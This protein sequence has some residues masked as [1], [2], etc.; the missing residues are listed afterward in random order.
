M[1]RN[2]FKLH[3]IGRFAKKRIMKSCSIALV[4]L[5]A[6]FVI[7]FL[8][9][10]KS[11]S[12]KDHDTSN[13]N[14]TIEV[15]LEYRESN[16]NAWTRRYSDDDLEIT[17]IDDENSDPSI[18]SSDQPI[19]EIIDSAV[20]SVINHGKSSSNENDTD[21]VFY[22]EGLTVSFINV[23]QGDS[24]LIQYTDAEEKAS[25][26]IDAGDNSCGTLVRN[27]LSKSGVESIDYVVCTHPDEDHIGGMASVIENIPINSQ[28]MWMP[29][30]EKDTKT[31][32]NLIKEAERNYIR[33]SMPE[34]G[35]E[36]HIGK[37]SFMVIAPLSEHKDENSNSIVIKLWY[38]DV[39]FLFTGDCEE[40]EEQE[41][42]SSS[43]AQDLASTILKVGHHGSQTSSCE[44]FIKAVS[45]KY[46]IIS[47]GKDN[48]YGHPH[49]DVV[50]R[51]NQYGCQ[52]K[53]TDEIGTVVMKTNGKSLVFIE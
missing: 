29:N 33:I 41:L 40:E 3:H 12:S 22:E 17:E 4:L 14:S 32:D 26:L 46:A 53:R 8:F 52:I 36:Y 44:E 15:S 43:Y 38:G 45:P 30:I 10:N 2:L 31:Y 23:G 20:S 50:D 49:K 1:K 37:A 7:S 48:S 5:I 42:L 16:P 35:K 51:L 18:I 11:L 39:S 21:D 19:N 24:I 28:T 13:S 25:M 47:C 27:Y 9:S 34:I 6:V